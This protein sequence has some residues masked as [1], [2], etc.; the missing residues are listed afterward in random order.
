[1]KRRDDEGAA[2]IDTSPEYTRQRELYSQMGGAARL[3]IAFQLSDAVRRLTQAGIR[4]RHPDYTEEDVRYAWAWLILGD[5]LC[6]TVWPDR[7]LVD[8]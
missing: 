3:T 1:M 8:P 4:R 2:P 5:Q 7:P 6:R